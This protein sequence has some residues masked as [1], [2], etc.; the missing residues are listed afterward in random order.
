MRRPDLRGL[1]ERVK[2]LIPSPPQPDSEDDSP[3]LTDRMK[4][5]LLPV[6]DRMIGFF[7]NLQRDLIQAEMD[8]REDVE[9]LAESIAQSLSLAIMISVAMVS[10]AII[11]SNYMFLQY[12]PI[13]APVALIFGT[14]TFSKRPSVQA[15]KRTRKLEKELPYALRHILIEVDAG[16]SLYQA[17][18]SVSDG[19]GEASNEFKKIVNEINAGTSEVTALEN[20]IL[21][22][23]SQEYRRALWQ[24]INALKSGTDVSTTLENLVDSI[25]EKQILSVEEYGKELNPY[26]L[27]YMMVAVI[28]PSLGVTFIMI[29]STFT[30]MNLGNNVFYGILIGLVLF[31][32]M[33]INLVKSKRPAV[34]A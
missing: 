4:E 3:G 23:P 2:E 6:A 7:P 28:M 24:I 16:I 5:H 20:A 22:N 34:K 9:Y 32:L 31:Q 14:F 19:Y 11:F 1:L 8:D 12:L 18:V 26:T 30:G 17:M 15:K 21:R 13:I 25:M 10:I 29:L 27:M 33:F